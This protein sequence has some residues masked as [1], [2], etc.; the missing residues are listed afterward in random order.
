[1]VK[2]TSTNKYLSLMLSWKQLL[3]SVATFLL[4]LAPS[5]SQDDTSTALFEGITYSRV[6]LTDPR[7]VV[8]YLIEIDLTADIEFVVTPADDLEEWDYTVRTTSD[9]V[10]AFGVQIAINGDFFGPV[11]NDGNAT[12]SA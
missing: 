2:R 12:E 6:E 11:R 7:Q 1:M 3:L 8:V 10:E 9:F 5:F 4:V